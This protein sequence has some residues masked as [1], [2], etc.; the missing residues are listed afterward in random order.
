MFFFNNYFYF[1]ELG[2]QAI[3]AIH[4][5]RKGTQNKWIWVI[6]FIPVIG[7]LAYLFTGILPVRNFGGWQEGISGIF[8]SP[9]GRI[10]RMENNLRFTDTFNNRVMLADAY[11]ATGR[12]NAAIELY[13]SSLTGAF[14][15]NEHVLIQLIVAYHERQQYDRVLPLAKRVYSRPQFAR[16]K[17]HILYAIALEKTGEAAMAEQEFRKMKARFSYFEAR[18]QYGLFLQRAGR[19]EEARQTFADIVDEAPHLSSRERR[20]SHTWIRQ[21][22]DELKKP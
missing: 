22:K 16:S 1:A 2:L 9:A 14:E 3:C 13:E 15:E 10:R 17:A 20:D 8:I 21:A 11:L 5:M 18:Y 4:C 19:K 6:V 12:T 7:C